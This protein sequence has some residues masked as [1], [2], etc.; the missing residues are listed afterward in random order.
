MR[1]Q[2]VCGKPVPEN[3]RLC[4]ECSKI[5][6]LNPKNWDP[7]LKWLVSDIQRDLDYER[8]HPTYSLETDCYEDITGN[9]RVKE[10]E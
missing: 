7:W 5:Y 8:N 2:C 4:N 1:R 3:R 6:G 10:T 9:Y